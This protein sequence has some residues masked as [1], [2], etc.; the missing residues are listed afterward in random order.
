MTLTLLGAKRSWRRVLTLAS[1]SLTMAVVAGTSHR[2]AVSVEAFT[3]CP[4]LSIVDP[5][6]CAEG[7][8][9]ITQNAIIALPPSLQPSQAASQLIAN[10]DLQVDLKETALNISVDG[11]SLLVPN[12]YY[13]PAHHFDRPKGDTSKQDFQ[14]SWFYMYGLRQEA[15]SLLSRPSPQP[16][17]IRD[18]L[19]ALGKALHALQDAYSHSN[20]VDPEPFGLQPS[21]YNQSSRQLQFNAALQSDPAI[22]RTQVEQST[23]DD[24]L[25]NVHLTLYSNQYSLNPENP[26]GGCVDNNHPNERADSLDNYCHEYFAKDNPGKNSH[27][28]A[29][30]FASARDAATIATTQFIQGIANEL[31]PC[32]W[33][34][35]IAYGTAG[36]VSDP[37]AVQS[38]GGTTGGSGGTGS[39]GTSSGG[40]TNVP[41]NA[42]AFDSDTSGRSEIYIQ[43]LDETLA[44]LNSPIIV[45]TGGAGQ[46]Q[47]QEPNW[48]LA[49]SNGVDSIGRIVYQFGAPGVRG[50]H[51][52]KPDGT[53][54]VQLT[55]SL[56]SIIP[57]GPQQGAH[58]PCA[59]S[60]DPAWS[61]D[62]RYIAYACLVNSLTTSNY[63]I[64]IHVISK[65]TAA[66]PVDFD[67]P[68]LTLPSSQELRP[69]WSPDGMMIAFV[70]SAPSAHG[71]GPNSKIAITQV[72]PA[73]MPVGPGGG[74]PY[75]QSLGQPG[76]LTDD[77][78]T[79][80]SPTWSP[81][82]QT[83]AFSTTRSGGHDIYRMSAKYGEGDPSALFQLTTSSAN[84]T[85]PAWSPYGTTMAFVSDRP[86]IDGSGSAQT[87][88]SQLWEMSATAGEADTFDL[89]QVTTDTSG[90]NNPAWNPLTAEPLNSLI[91]VLPSVSVVTGVSVPTG[92]GTVFVSDGGGNAISG[93]VVTI[94]PPSTGT[95]TLAFAE[96]ASLT[97]SFGNLNFTVV[98]P[99]AQQVTADYPLVVFA[100]DPATGRTGSLQST[101][102]VL[103]SGAA[104]PPQPPGQ[105]PLPPQ[106]RLPVGQPVFRA[107][108][109]QLYTQQAQA[110]SIEE[111]QNLAIEFPFSIV[112]APAFGFI[113][114][115]EWE[116]FNAGMIAMSISRA[117]NYLA[118]ANDPP[119]PNFTVVALP[120]PQLTPVVLGTGGPF[121]LNTL[122]L[123]NQTLKEKALVN[124]YLGALVTSINRYTTALTA[125]DRA[126]AGLQRNAI[127]S[128]E[129]NLTFLLQNDSIVT[130][131]FLASLHQDGLSDVPLAST[132]I[133]TLQST[134]ATSG[135]PSQIT[136]A[137]QALGLTANNIQ[138]LQTSFVNTPAASI[139]GS[140]F[141]SIQSDA[142]MSQE[143]YI[144]LAQASPVVLPTAPLITVTGGTFSFNGIAHGATASAT[145]VSGIPVSGSFTFSY[146]PGGSSPPVDVGTYSVTAQ[147]ATA[148]PSYANGMGTGTITITSTSQTASTS[149]TASMQF[150]RISHQATLLADGLV[151]VSGGQNSGTAIPKSELYNPTAATWSLTGSNVIPRFDHSATLLQDG[152]VLAA[153]GISSIGECSQ[154]VTAETY[155]PTTGQWS[156]TDR[157]P[158]PVGT[159]HAAIRMQDGRVL[160]TGG[161]DRCGTIFN[162][163]QIFNPTTN[164]WSTKA[165]MNV[166]RQFHTIALLPDG[167]VLVAGG[168][169]SSSLS[170]VPSAEIYDPTAG[171]WT[172]IGS[173]ATARQTACNGYT[174]TFL[175]NLP[176][177]S[178]LAAGGFSGSSCPA[179]TPQRTVAAATVNPS[180]VQLFNIGQ[181]LALSVTAQMSDGA[182]EPFTGPLQFSSGDTTVV[183]VDSS[184]FV[185]AVGTGTTAIT[186]SGTGISPVNVP[187]T[188]ASRQLTTISVSPTSIVAIGSGV[189][190][191]LAVNG[192]YSD[193]SQQAVTTGLTFT[194]SNTAVVTV[195][196]TGLVTT[197]GNGT[198]TITVS[199]QGV[200][201]AQVTVLVKSLVSI[202][203]SPTS[204]TLNGLGQTQTLTVTGLYSDGS[205]QVLTSNLSFTSSN[206]LVAQVNLSGFVTAVAN[207]TSTITVSVSGVTAIQV[208][209]TVVAPLLS[210][211]KSHNG[212]FTQGQQGAAYT[213]IVSNAAGAGPSTG[214]ITVTD[215]VPTGLTLAS[216]VGTGWVCGTASCTRND[217]LA[218]GG[219]YPPIA[220][221]VN[222]ANSAAASVINTAT[223]SNRGSVSAVA[224]D[225][226]TITAGTPVILSVS[227]NS[228]QLG[229]QNLSITLTG[230]FTNWVQSTTTASFGAGV[231]VVSLTV[232]SNTSATAVLNIDPTAT[233]GAR[234]VTVTTGS[235]VETLSSGFTVSTLST[236]CTPEPS[237][238]VS[239]WAGD[240]NTSDLL[241][242]NNPSASNAVTFVPGEVG[243]GF[244]FGPG[245]YIDIPASQS[246]ANP[247]FTLSAWVR[248]D[249]PGP[250][251][252]FL[253]N[254]IVGQDIDES[255]T[256]VL[257]SWRNSDDRFTFVDG[258]ISSEQVISQDAFPPGN[259]Y[260]VT[261]SYDGST[262][263]L[264]VN[265]QIEATDSVAKTTAYSSIPWTIGSSSSNIRGQGFPR[266]WNGVIDDVQAFNVALSESAIQAIYAAGNLGECRGQPAIESVAPSAGQQGQQNLTVA[267]TGEFTNWVQGAT[268]A[269]FGAGIAVVSLTVNSATSATAVVN[270]GSTAM[271]GVR[272]VTIATG[273]E[274][275]ALTGGFAV[276]QSTNTPPVVSAGPD[277]TV[278]ESWELLVSS[279]YCC[280][281]P[282]GEAV[283]RY[284]GITGAFLGVVTPISLSNG[285]S[286]PDELQVDS[287]NRLYV[288]VRGGLNGQPGGIYRYD[289][290]TGVFID[291]FLPIGVNGPGDAPEYIFGPDN[292]LYVSSGGAGPNVT[293][294]DGAT[295]AFIDVF[296]TDPQGNTT[297]GLTFGP[298][299]NLY[300]ADGVSVLEFNGPTGSF[301]QTFIQGPYSSPPVFG[302]DGNVYM[303]TGDS[304]SVVR[305]DGK[306]G[307]FI[308]TFVSP[309]SGGLTRAAYLAFGPD[310]N[311]YVSD[312]PVDNSGFVLRYDGK[313][314]QFIDA[315]I[316]PGSGGLLRAT[317]ILFYRVA[318]SVVLSGVVTDD[319]LPLGGTLTFTWSQVSGPGVVVFGSANSV[320]TTAQFSVPGTYVLRLT[321]SDSQLSSS[322]ETT[323]TVN[324]N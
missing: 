165:S 269:N 129:D 160:V 268:T 138:T 105:I 149:P 215:A 133:A 198:A 93:A 203:V 191:P 40:T 318:G 37:C 21:T 267:L 18:A 117:N 15:I 66:D 192:Q 212:S 197:V 230:Q 132:D 253:G 283:L 310:G 300:V 263:T 290:A 70:T 170:A 206:P 142:T 79:N 156:L 205:Q 1:I 258:N 56:N 227:P 179:I 188:V 94:I 51:Q 96:S 54:D 161:G 6:T 166:A 207:G 240:G 17:Q 320:S 28:T 97:D 279:N 36:A 131:A 115:A 229:Q 314:G 65:G 98:E 284:D 153:G 315:F 216:M 46:Q 22:P 20:Y 292:N 108:T 44:P 214:T 323:I 307:A 35:V 299:G 196:P 75:V 45:T 303:T 152:R 308:D 143:A 241:G 171:T 204:L 43:G 309:G 33:Q 312:V 288:S 226:T 187:V 111:L 87:G 88:I 47:A 213:I 231:T 127:L 23:L 68:L 222:V 114:S 14:I 272:T 275:D 69:A 106:V 190:Q 145:G 104:I 24:L 48:S 8:Q 78:F 25:A 244:T 225:L 167:R 280:Q 124:A 148:D 30:A 202:V 31:Q 277:Q 59:D 61:P 181:T 252:D 49:A 2:L 260:L 146:N 81:D 234:T 136:Q 73:V 293:R 217:A 271:V 189:T 286:Y 254:W 262:F 64:W 13:D 173:M 313:T 39:G 194:S 282:T 110:S 12:S 154:N 276:T 76:I 155:D 264:Y 100:Y 265:G 125:G 223:V 298:D 126:S 141:T 32:E 83:I 84:D 38:G 95:N 285:I 200:P 322:D 103:G 102:H 92:S 250:N 296:A 311:L 26:Y 242:A 174:Q 139:A 278:A 251:D 63:D 297:A 19:T 256:S 247:Q 168:I 291:A 4:Q 135:L 238:L 306:T 164:Q 53:G 122:I 218:G 52:I 55:P 119:D 175:A 3:S 27:S 172:P 195:D 62:G 295:G 169:T 86:S 150:A 178:V 41:A 219:S 137:L 184:G 158:S 319:G 266:T 80:V 287:S 9:T 99:T 42:I 186:V 259:F 257:L 232:N 235:E 128:Y 144:T 5:L 304:G 85:S 7:H 281:P 210:V 270:I 113:A 67:Y 159:G 120:S 177:G 317:G 91:L 208:P 248:P 211:M 130:K 89:K 321:A 302:P 71:P 185:I 224:T 11:S 74:V 228:G 112:T 255:D 289:L 236:V 305:F 209:V 239:W 183:T 72:L 246:L 176:S 107:Q 116:T 109:K 221:T 199:A 90:H 220:V 82:S 60:R 182:T 274:Q 233:S 50:I 10:A 245:G 316:P 157:L 201:S 243:T 193:G 134:I 273:T 16:Q 121:S 294:Y 123:M 147:F 140:L 151:L 118:L 77:I 301:I 57:G 261:A 249:G 29:S 58:Y 324:P 101:I 180:S 237:G 34:R 163:V 162:T